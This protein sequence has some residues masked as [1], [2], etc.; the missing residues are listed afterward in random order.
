[1]K[2]ILATSMA[3][4]TVLGTTALPMQSTNAITVSQSIYAS[5][6]TSSTD[7]YTETVS[8]I[9][10]RVNNDWSDFEKVL[11]IHD[12]LTTHC[13][14][15]LTY[16]HY[17][18]YS[19]IVDKTAVC[20]GYSLAFKDLMNRLNVPCE[21]VT[22]STLN[23][24]WNAVKVDS[25]WYYIDVT[26]DDPIYDRLGRANHNYFLKSESYFQQDSTNSS[27][28][29][30]DYKFTGDL[31]ESDIDGTMFDDLYNSIT[32][33]LVYYNGYWYGKDSNKIKQY[34]ASNDGLAEVKTIKTLND[35]WYVWESTNS[36]WVGNFSGLS[37]IGNSL[38]Y[39]TPQ[40][41]IA[42]DLD[43]M[44]EKTVYTLDET[45]KTLGYIFGSFVDNDYTLY[46]S[47]NQSPSEI[48]TNKSVDIHEHTYGDWSITKPAT[49]TEDG[50]KERKCSLCG[51]IETETILAAGHTYSTEWT[52]DKEATETEEGSKSHHCTVCGEKADITAIPKLEVIESSSDTDSSSQAESS[53]AAGSPSDID[54]SS[55]IDSSSDADEEIVYTSDKIKV[56]KAK[57]QSKYRSFLNIT[58]SEIN[59]LTAP[60][61]YERYINGELVHTEEISDAYKYYLV[62]STSYS[63][64][65][66]TYYMFATS[67]PA[68]STDRLVDVYTLKT[69]DKTIK[70]TR[71]IFEGTS[72]S[73]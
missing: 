58:T 62:N 21:M 31:K 8:D 59:N 23:H 65:D 64:P 13:E 7:I 52:I 48:S 66:G 19:A 18:A 38:Y 61:T 25:H 3:A 57:N 67:T 45:E 68:K 63:A 33:S 40:S 24:A 6:D 36:Y 71:V 27:H 30:S 43:T 1:M 60:V 54:S 37:G 17:S 46:Y 2:K 47:L 11:Y 41:V 56:Q 34:T 50:I 15:D 49:C 70:Y 28:Q 29:A 35:I 32:T 72:E 53:N 20:Q 22:S 5:A 9:L 12:Y 39:S 4:I 55:N 16:S 14:Y 26:W 69:T 73:S 44:S 10:S 51:N 42:L